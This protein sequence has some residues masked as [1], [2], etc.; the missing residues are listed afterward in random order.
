MH[1]LL[2]RYEG[3]ER[4][5]TGYDGDRSAKIIRRKR[6]REKNGSIDAGSGC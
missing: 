6:D 2:E 3:A 1:K 5:I 4:P